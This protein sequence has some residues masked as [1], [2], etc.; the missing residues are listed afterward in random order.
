MNIVK[1]GVEFPQNIS[2]NKEH[3][4]FAVG[5]VKPL[6]HINDIITAFSK[7]SCDYKDFKLYIFG[8]FE[9]L[10]Y[11]KY[12]REMVKNLNLDEKIQ[13]LGRISDDNKNKF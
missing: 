11:E 8:K 7:I 12:C 5:H 10:K 6:K 2:Y 13:F 9:N 4:I 1:S 3:I